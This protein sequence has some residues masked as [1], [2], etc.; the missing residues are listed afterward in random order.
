MPI[1]RAVDQK[2]G[3]SLF[4]IS[5]S[6]ANKACKLLKKAGYISVSQFADYRS[7]EALSAC[8]SAYDSAANRADYDPDTFAARNAE[9]KKEGRKLR[10]AINRTQD[11]ISSAYVSDVFAQLML[12]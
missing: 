8:N 6:L 4:R 10:G 9:S 1:I 11:S 12:Q 5:A 3:V 2:N 7:N